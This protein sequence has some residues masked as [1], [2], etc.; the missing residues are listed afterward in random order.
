MSSYRQLLYHIVI[1]TKNSK[2][3][4]K[5][6][7]TSQLYSYITGIIKN[8]NGHLYQINGTKNHIHLLTD[9]HPSVALADF[10]REIKVST[11][12]WI[13]EIDLFPDFDGWSDGYGSFTVSHSD[14]G[15]LIDYIKRQRIHHKKETF[16][17]EYRRLLMEYGISIDERFFP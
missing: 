14:L 3:V 12:K 7:K 1:R 15:M 13:K 5:E 16:D 11:S 4:I 6:E 8:K 2:P 10:V 9:I 17:A